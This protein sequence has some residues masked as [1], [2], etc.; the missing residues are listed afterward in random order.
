MRETEWA[1]SCGEGNDFS[2]GIQRRFF[3]CATVDESDYP[4]LVQQVEQWDEDIDECEG[5]ESEGEQDID[6]E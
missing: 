4:W 1:V 3:T 2:S 6:V 5:S